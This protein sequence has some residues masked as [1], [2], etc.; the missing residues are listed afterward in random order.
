MPALSHDF[1]LC[2]VLAVQMNVEEFIGTLI[3]ILTRTTF[4]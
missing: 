2:T 1:L 3:E 4:D